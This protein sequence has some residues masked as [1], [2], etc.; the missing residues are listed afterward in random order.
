MTALIPLQKY[1]KYKYSGEGWIAEIPEHWDVNKLK[2]VF[3]EKKH[4]KNLSLNCGAISFGSVVR[5]DD[6]KITESTKASYQEVLNGEF[7][8]NPLNLNYD[9][10]SLRI[11]LSKIDVVV[12]AGYLVLKEKIK[13]FLHWKSRTQ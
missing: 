10:I 13:I 2:H 8:I 5:K 6:E 4:A 11:A 9:L 7:L 12:S 3:Y 1:E